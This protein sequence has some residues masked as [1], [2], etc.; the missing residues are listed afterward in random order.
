MLDITNNNDDTSDNNKDIIKDTNR[1]NGNYTKNTV[2]P[3]PPLSADVFPKYI[4]L[5][6]SRSFTQ[7]RMTVLILMD[8]IPGCSV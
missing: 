2:E 6:A 8:L 1:D 4:G 5:F 3:Q 7:Q